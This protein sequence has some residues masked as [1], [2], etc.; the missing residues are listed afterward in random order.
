M[1]RIHDGIR[2]RFETNYLGPRDPRAERFAV[3]L[4]TATT[5][6]DRWGCC[7]VLEDGFAA[8]NAA[9]RL[10][11]EHGML[12]TPS[13]RRPGVLPPE[14]LVEVVHV[15]R[16]R[17]RV[18]YRARTRAL[19][20]TS[21]AIL[22]HAVLSPSTWPNLDATETPA[23]SLHGHSLDSQEDAD[24]LGIPCAVT[25]TQFSTPEDLEATRAKLARAPFPAHDAWIR[26]GHG[27]IV[28]GRSVSDALDRLRSLLDHPRPS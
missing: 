12:L 23:V 11:T 15:D 9:L 5:Q 21:D 10:D 22:H 6:M 14:D 19:R 2:I 25:E 7:P 16:P 28:A 26:R 18:D 3:A 17:W 24:R 20:P 13:G 1:E 8:G 27:F 4:A